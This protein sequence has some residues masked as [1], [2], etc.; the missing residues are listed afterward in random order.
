MTVYD[1]NL[2]TLRTKRVFKMKKKPFFIIFKG[3]SMKQK[4]QIF[5][6]GESPTLREVSPEY[7][8]IFYQILFKVLG[9]FLRSAFK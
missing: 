9:N 2:I 5:S 7:N 6:E 3:L 4:T 8:V 1:K